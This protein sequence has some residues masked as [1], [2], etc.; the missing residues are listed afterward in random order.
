MATWS[1]I[2]KKLECDYLADSLKGR[3][4]YFATSYSYASDHV[5]RAAIKLDGVEIVKSDYYKL[6]QF[7]W[8][9]Y[10]EI[11]DTSNGADISDVWKESWREAVNKGGF[12]NQ[13]FYSAFEEY[14][15]Q[16]IES[17]LKSNNAL[18][19]IFAIMDRRVGKRRLK[20]LVEAWENE[21]NWIK[22]FLHLRLE[23]EG[24]LG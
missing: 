4:S 21:Q 8:E 9:S 1:G 14:D 19:R 20:D 5:G 2:K 11:K 6:Q 24:V 16:S 12:D 23:A 18:V 10:Q 22:F 3:I 13:M 7:Q 15:N 17:S